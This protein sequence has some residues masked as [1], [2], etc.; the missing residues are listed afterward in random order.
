MSDD[1]DYDDNSSPTQIFV[2][3]LILGCK[4]EIW[5]AT[6]RSV[7]LGVGVHDPLKYVGGLRVRLTPKMSQ[8]FIR[9]CCWI[10]AS[11]TSS[12]IKDLSKMEGKTTFSKRLQA[13]RKRDS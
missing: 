11:F 5:G 8:S 4:A 6:A 3:M 9:N 2:P 10:T 12:R 7:D 13:V 1:A